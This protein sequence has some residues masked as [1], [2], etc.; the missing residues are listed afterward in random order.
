MD[1]IKI[2]VFLASTLCGGAD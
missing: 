1:S 2:P